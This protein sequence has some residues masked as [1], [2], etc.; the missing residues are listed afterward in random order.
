MRRKGYY[1]DPDA[2]RMYMTHE[3]LTFDKLSQYL[4]VSKTSI[5]RWLNNK[6]CINGGKLQDLGYILNVNPLLLIKPSGTETSEVHVNKFIKTIPIL[7][8][9]QLYKVANACVDQIHTLKG[10]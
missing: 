7:S 2:V 10:E 6:Y 3:G 1:L 5:F 4:K 8:E 9:A